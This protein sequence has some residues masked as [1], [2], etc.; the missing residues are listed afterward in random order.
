VGD[1][2]RGFEFFDS[3]EV[4]IQLKAA[5]G[6][7]APDQMKAMAVVS[8]IVESDGWITGTGCQPHMCLDGKWALA[9]NITTLVVSA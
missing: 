8:P 2:L 7:T 3:P 4:Q 6:P 9:I 1:R 5:L